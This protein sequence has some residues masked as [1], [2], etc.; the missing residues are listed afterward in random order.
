[1]ISVFWKVIYHRTLKKTKII[2][3]FIVI[4]S[5]NVLF[6]I[7]NQ[8]FCFK[9]EKMCSHNVAKNEHIPHCSDWDYAGKNN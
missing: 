4:I 3:K 9:T 5:T 2:Y 7:Q 8:F 1:M 6:V